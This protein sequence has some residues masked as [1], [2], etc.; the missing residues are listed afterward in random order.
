MICAAVVGYPTA[1]GL[2]ECAYRTNIPVLEVDLS[3]CVQRVF[4]KI[5][6]VS[7]FRKAAF[8]YSEGMK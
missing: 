3:S 5:V 2:V 4:Q 7:I 1:S 6:V 8:G